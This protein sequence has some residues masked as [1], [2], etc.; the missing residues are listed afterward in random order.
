MAKFYV[1]VS[2]GMLIALF[3]DVYPGINLKKAEARMILSYFDRSDYPL[4]LDVIHRQLIRFDSQGVGSPEDLDTLAD[5]VTY[6]ADINFD[7]TEEEE[8]AVIPD[9]KR[10]A[11][12]RA[13]PEAPGP[14]H[15]V[16]ERI[17][18]P[19]RHGKS[20]GENSPGDLF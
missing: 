4:K 6:C 16:Y 7:L 20:P 14:P 1:D 19:E 17:G 15:R 8:A 18:G 3:E 11:N 9:E 10:L 12:L 5:V 13:P 2:P